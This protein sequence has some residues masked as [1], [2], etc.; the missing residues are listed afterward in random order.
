MLIRNV[1]REVR[2]LLRKFA[3]IIVCLGLVVAAV[4]CNGENQTEPDKTGE[5]KTAEIMNEFQSLTESDTQKDTIVEEVAAF[6]ENNIKHVSR[7]DA[8]KMVNEFEKLQK[9]YLPQ[10]ENLFFDDDI[11]A[12]V[13]NEY[14]SITEQSAIKDP[15]L[16]ELITK[17]N[18]SGYRVET[19]E[20]TYFPIIDYE[21]YKKYRDHVTADLQDYIDIMAVES[22]T[23]PAKDAALVISWDEIVKRALN[24]ER[25]INTHSGSEKID[26]I[27]QLY[28]KY[29]TFILYGCNNTPLFSY[30]TKTFN[31]QAREAYL[32]AVANNG[33]SELIKDLEEYLNVVIKNDNKLTSRVEEYRASLRKKYIPEQNS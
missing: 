11:Q 3:L 13:N 17:T 22:N 9:E 19:A 20:G 23:V 21:F 10:L 15:A 28:Q 1:I 26:E 30:D 31:P 2:N 6:I 5:Q 25:F 24:Q 33:S 18:N 29:I 12:G 16:K 14:K 4:G 27:K 7:E 8:S 32:N